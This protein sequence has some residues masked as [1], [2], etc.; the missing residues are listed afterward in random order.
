MSDQLIRLRTEIAGTLRNPRTDTPRRVPGSVRRATVID[1]RHPDGPGGDLVLVSS[2]RDART[3]G[4]GSL[5]VLDAVQLRARLAPD[6]TLVEV[7]GGP[8]A[9]RAL[10]GRRVIGGF[11]SA[12]AAAVPDDAAAGT[13]VHQVVD[14]WVGAVL[15]SGMAQM[16][17]TAGEVTPEAVARQN[18]GLQA[19]TDLCAGWAADASLISSTLEY[20]VT[21][22]SLG[23]LAPDLRRADD[24]DGLPEHD[25]LLPGDSRR[26]RRLDIGAG[27][28]SLPLDVH[29]RDSWVGVDG[30]IRVVHE[31]SLS[32]GFDP[33]AGAITQVVPTAHVL[34]WPECPAALASAHRVVGLPLAELRRTVRTDFTGISTCTHLNDVLRSLADVPALAAHTRAGG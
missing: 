3:G 21:P 23:P 24:P 13:V 27:P 26:F 7:E 15:V 29:F 11:R 33:R 30:Q 14:D 19:N 16:D 17:V 31:Y 5:E 22:V 2:G 12:L 34:P 32:G 9:L 6:R 8:P 20:G 1:T 18:I 4:D 28:A 10:V 25:D